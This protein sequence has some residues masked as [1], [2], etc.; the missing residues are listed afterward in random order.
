M[1]IRN[2]E[3]PRSVDVKKR[4]GEGEFKVETILTKEEMGQSGRLFVRGTLEKGHS[5]GMHPH[6]GDIEVCYFLQGEGLVREDGGVENIVHAGDT[7]IV[8]SGCSHE[9]ISIGD[10]PLVYLA[11]VVFPEGRA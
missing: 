5:V 7:N 4:G 9:I 2:N 8:P 3:Y 1:I 6:I 11:V 10:E